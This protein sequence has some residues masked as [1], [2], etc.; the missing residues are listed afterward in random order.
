MAW[1]SSSCWLTAEETECCCSSALLLPLQRVQREARLNTQRP[2][3]P[4]L[5]HDFHTYGSWSMKDKPGLLFHWLIA[6]SHIINHCLIPLR[7]KFKKSGP[8]AFLF[9]PSL[10][11]LPWIQ[12]FVCSSER[13]HE[14]LCFLLHCYLAS[15]WS[16]DKGFKQTLT[17]FSFGSLGYCVFDQ[18]KIN[19]GNPS[20]S[21]LAEAQM[22][23]K[24]IFRW[25]FLRLGTWI[26]YTFSAIIIFKKSTL[27]QQR[28]AWCSAILPKL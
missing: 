1:G 17:L 6:E 12:I 22:Q 24:L 4:L 19:H 8:S 11:R 21:H 9:S 13:S 16:F 18:C 5:P 20:L 14:G 23:L 10:S 25:H 28:K 27:T 7:D 2:T 26:K 15:N 3:L